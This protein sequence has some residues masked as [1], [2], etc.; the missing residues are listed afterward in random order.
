MNLIFLRKIIKQ[1]Q[2][3]IRKLKFKKLLHLF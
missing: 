1:N 2:D 3:Y